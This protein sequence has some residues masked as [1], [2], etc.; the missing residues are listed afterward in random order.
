M[1][2]KTKHHTSFINRIWIYHYYN[3][4][5]KNKNHWL[6]IIIH[7]FLPGMGFC[8]VVLIQ[9]KTATEPVTTA[10]TRNTVIADT[11]VAIPTIMPKSRRIKTS[12]ICCRV[13]WLMP[14]GEKSYMYHNVNAIIQ[15]QYNMILWIQYRW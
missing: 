7:P 9:V 2:C 14:E 15:T 8:F 4:Q 11:A 10:I 3:N 1:T 6:I 12:I 5:K 13:T